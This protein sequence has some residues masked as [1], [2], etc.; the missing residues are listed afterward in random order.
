MPDTT[1]DEAVL[2]VF[3]IAYTCTAAVVMLCVCFLTTPSDLMV[4]F[5]LSHLSKN[6]MLDM[7]RLVSQESHAAHMLLTCR[8]CCIKSVNMLLT[9][10]SHAAYMQGLLHRVCSFYV[11]YFLLYSHIRTTVPP[12]D[13]YT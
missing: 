4:E 5:T 3:S 13:M 7:H 8:A 11:T 1:C 9:C 2:V 6:L 12:V 10:C